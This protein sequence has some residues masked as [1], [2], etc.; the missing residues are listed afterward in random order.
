MPAAPLRLEEFRYANFTSTGR[1]RLCCV[2]SVHKLPIGYSSERFCFIANDSVQRFIVRQ[3][4][5]T[6]GT[7]SSA[8][9]GIEYNKERQLPTLYC[10]QFSFSRR[11]LVEIDLVAMEF[12]V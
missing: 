3:K 11:L 10:I 9:I 5:I 7:V 8:F 2:S 4:W 12:S 1:P 6:K